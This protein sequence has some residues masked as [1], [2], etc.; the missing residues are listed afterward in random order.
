MIGKLDLYLPEPGMPATPIT[1][2]H[3][4]E[5]WITE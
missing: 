5:R 2:A 3:V 1:L 4:S